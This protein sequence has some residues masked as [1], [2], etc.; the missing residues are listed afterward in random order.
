ME[1][2]WDSFWGMGA[3]PAG[4]ALP[5]DRPCSLLSQSP[6]PTNPTLAFPFFPPA[7]S[8]SV[9]APSAVC[10]RGRLGCAIPFPWAGNWGAGPCPGPQP[11]L[12]PELL[13]QPDGQQSSPSGGGG[14]SV[15][16]LGSRNFTNQNCCLL[17]IIWGL[18]CSQ[19]DLCPEF[20]EDLG[21]HLK[22]RK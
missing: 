5:G 17:L 6:F 1:Q 9:P 22:K 18:R 13:P 14:C 21:G 3:P 11:L 10:S 20:G 4:T 15:P 2:G 12:T 8:S 7:G 16:V 19:W